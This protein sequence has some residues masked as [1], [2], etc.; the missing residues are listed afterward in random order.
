MEGILKIWICVLGSS[1]HNK[2]RFLMRS[3][4]PLSPH[5]KFLHVYS[6]DQALERAF[7]LFVFRITSIESC[8]CRHAIRYNW[9]GCF[10]PGWRNDHSFSSSHSCRQQ[11]R[12]A[13]QATCERTFARNPA[14]ICK[15]QDWGDIDRRGLDAY[16]INADLCSRSA[17]ANP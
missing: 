7:C 15:P 11:Q 5:S 2:S 3:N 8:S 9:R 17:P 14:K 10:S 6:V 13:H 1:T 16:I 4:H 12:I